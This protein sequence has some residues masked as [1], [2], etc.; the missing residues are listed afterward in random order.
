MMA[1]RLKFEI[2]ILEHQVSKIDLECSAL[3]EIATISR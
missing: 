2:Y 1:F 3:A